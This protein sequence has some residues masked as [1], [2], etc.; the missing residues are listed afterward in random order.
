MQQVFTE[1]QYVQPERLDMAFTLCICKPL[2][3]SELDCRSIL[4]DR[5]QY[6]V[7]LNYH[8][9]SLQCT[10]SRFQQP[11]FPPIPITLNMFL[12]HESQRKLFLPV[13]LFLSVYCALAMT[14]HCGTNSLSNCSELLQSFTYNL[15]HQEVKGDERNFPNLNSE[16]FKGKLAREWSLK[17]N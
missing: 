5:F 2:S 9:K 11:K 10:V 3:I 17:T 6:R 7:L 14:K 4:A 16:T 8:L 1:K 15:S 13:Q 12:P